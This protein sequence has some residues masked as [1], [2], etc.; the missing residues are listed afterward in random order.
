M[1]KIG[2]GTQGIIFLCTLCQK[3]SKQQQ[4]QIIQHHVTFSASVHLHNDNS[5]QTE[6][7]AKYPSNTT[8]DNS[9]NQGK[10]TTSFP[11]FYTYPWLLVVLTH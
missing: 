3:N 9:R 11:R 2:G 7:L 4:L 8:A 10:V 6:S 1:E 5:L